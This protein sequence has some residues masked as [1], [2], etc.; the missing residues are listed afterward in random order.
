MNATEMRNFCGTVR[1]LVQFVLDRQEGS[2]DDAGSLAARAIE[3]TTGKRSGYTGMDALASIS[4]VVT[5]AEKRLPVYPGNK[6][7][8]STVRVGADSE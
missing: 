2:L 6:R 1:E 4:K 3:Y 5:D 7:Q 8:A